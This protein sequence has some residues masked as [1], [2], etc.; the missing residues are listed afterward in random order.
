MKFFR[1]MIEKLNPAPYE[2]PPGDIPP[3][4]VLHGETEEVLGEKGDVVGTRTTFVPP[5][6]EPIG[7]KYRKSVPMEYNE[8]LEES[9]ESVANPE[10]TY[11]QPIDIFP[12]GI[13]PVTGRFVGSDQTNPSST[14]KVGEGIP[15]GKLV[16]LH[17]VGVTRSLYDGIRGR[18]SPGGF[19]G[20]EVENRKAP[21]TK[22][23]G[24]PPK[25]EYKP[26]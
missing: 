18:R 1:R 12:Q 11:T 6:L 4:R 7:S 24:V 15:E 2:E 22:G 17:T 21:P 25:L 23:G 26:W 3:T 8:D 19:V 9:E 10:M 16:E 14:P 5:P 20:G 13:E